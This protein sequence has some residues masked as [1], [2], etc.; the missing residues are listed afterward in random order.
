[1]LASST[2]AL[3]RHLEGG[4]TQLGLIAGGAQRGDDGGILD[5]AH[6]TP[7]PC[8]AACVGDL[9]RALG[10]RPGTVREP[11]VGGGA[12][13]RAARS[14]W[15]GARVL[16]VDLYRQAEGFRWCH[17][18]EIGDY[19]RMPGFLG[20]DEVDVT[21]GNPDFGGPDERRGRKPGDPAYVGAHH[22]VRAIHT[23]RVVGFILPLE[24]L[25]VQAVH[26]ALWSQHAPTYMR[27]LVPRP[28]DV[29]RGPMW[30]VWSDEALDV[31][32]EGVANPGDARMLS[33]L[34]W[35]SA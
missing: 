5:G 3:E 13:V 4:V 7:D 22:A 14:T 27:P 8:A 26:A 30:V 25:A 1:M 16:G 21:I 33:P 18:A 6:Y 24:W 35:R 11:S 23:S 17:L 31:G 12:F 9:A 34:L 28:W 10:W 32:D 19:L 15:P 20:G 29:L 2:L